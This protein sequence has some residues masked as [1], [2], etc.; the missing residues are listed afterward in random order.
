M[1]LGPLY[2]LKFH[3]EQ[4]L[5]KWKLSIDLKCG[6]VGLAFGGADDLISHISVLAA[7]L[8]DRASGTERAAGDKAFLF[9]E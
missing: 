8:L 1:L 9:P 2:C 4:V 7:G 5:G 6:F 3:D